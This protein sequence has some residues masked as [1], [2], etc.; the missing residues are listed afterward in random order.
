MGMREVEA[1]AKM[2]CDIGVNNVVIK[3][4]SF[5]SFAIVDQNN[6]I[7]YEA[8]RKNECEIILAKAKEVTN[9]R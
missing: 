6:H 2:Q 5:K 7:V 9:D 4:V 3:P 8:R 1:I